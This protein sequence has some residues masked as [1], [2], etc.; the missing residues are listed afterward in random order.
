MKFKLLT[1]F[2]LLFFVINSSFASPF[3][4]GEL[5]DEITESEVQNLDEQ[6]DKKKDLKNEEKPKVNESNSLENEALQIDVNEKLKSEEK[7]QEKIEKPKQFKEM[8]EVK[9]K[10]VNIHSGMKSELKLKIGE[11]ETFDGMNLQLEK[12]YKSIDE[13]YDKISIAYIALSSR[14]FKRNSTTFSSDLALSS[15][16]ASKY[17]VKADCF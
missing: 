7:D 10:I 17:I 12:C 6:E 8:S 1:K 16:I 9:L 4:V 2:F 14:D 13:H 3:D 15:V 11:Q 5:E